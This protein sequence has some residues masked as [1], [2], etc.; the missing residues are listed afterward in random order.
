MQLRYIEYAGGTFLSCQNRS[1]PPAAHALPP[2]AADSPA[3]TAAPVPAS[4]IAPSATAPSAATAAAAATTIIAAVKAFNGHGRAGDAKASA[5]A[6]PAAPA[7]AMAA[8][9]ATEPAA[10]PA[11]PAAPKRQE[12]IAP[13]PPAAAA[14]EIVPMAADTYDLV[15]VDDVRIVPDTGGAPVDVGSLFTSGEIADALLAADGIKVADLAPA[16]AANAASPG[17]PT[18]ARPAAESLSREEITAQALTRLAERRAREAQ[19]HAEREIERRQRHEAL[20]AQRRASADQAQRNTER[21]SKEANRRSKRAAKMAARQERA[22]A[23]A[24]NRSAIAA[25]ARLSAA[26]AAVASAR[27]RPSRTRALAANIGA[28]LGLVAAI[29]ISI[30]Y[31]SGEHGRFER[32]ARISAA[33][34]TAA[35]PRVAAASTPA[36]RPGAP[37][38]SQAALLSLA[39]VENTVERKSFQ[40][41]I[42]VQRGDNFFMLLMRSGVPGAEAQ[43]ANISLAGVYDVRKMKAG[44]LIT[45]D[46]GILGEEHNRFLGVRFD[47]NF[48]RT[49][50]IQRQSRGDFV[51]TE[52]KKELVT[53]ILR[54]NGI[55]DHSVFQAGLQAGLPPEPVVR[56]INLFAY[57]VDLQR[58]V[59]KGDTFETL[60]EQHRDRNGDI[61]RHGNIL[62]AS[63]TLQGHTIKLYRWQGEDGEV[64]YFSEKG[65]SSRK[66]LMRTPIDGARLSSG[67]GYRR[68]P[69][70]GYSKMHQGVDFAA[71]TGTPI[72][73]A[74]F[75]Q[76]ERI[77]WHG[78]YGNSITIR[79]NK[80]YAT[81]YGH[82]SGFAPGMT[83]GKRVNQGD[84]VGFV[85]TTGMSTGPHLHY[86]VHLAGKQ[87]DPLS[88]KLPSRQKLAGAELA[89]YIDMVKTVDGRF[90]E[91]AKN[92][93]TGNGITLAGDQEADTGCVNG[94][95]LDPTDKKACE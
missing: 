73:A 63:L 89:R 30:W 19:R 16:N 90:N 40:R 18:P 3:S 22:M 27:R 94:A 86:E 15:S 45:V 41:V 71:P 5:P 13:S 59:Q 42:R 95:R 54:T 88:L 33:A 36:T 23:K 67:F 24:R 28:T 8:A 32:E 43:L 48:D 91:L 4:A 76:I 82:M 7:P 52:L 6:A 60:I 10:A 51:A 80:D 72:F 74:G 68:H 29:G 11:K 39:S 57:D 77:G 93:A 75:G 47:S 17:A 2:I 12:P 64:E 34:A 55:I 50:A 78:G 35:S 87:I 85:G 37:R 79:H 38:I 62:F 21:A 31:F 69:V 92:G 65:E 61:V 53:L 81:L 70:L 56:M 20:A 58:D 9:P 66:A 44:Q 25:P 26:Q 46:F 49:V 84:I 1:R 83:V 14:S